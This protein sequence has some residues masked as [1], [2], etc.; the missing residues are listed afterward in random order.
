MFRA[1]EETIANAAAIRDYL[2][3]GPGSIAVDE[4]DLYDRESRRAFLLLWNADTRAARKV[5]GWSVAG[6]NSSTCSRP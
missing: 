2:N 6:E 3:E 5:S 4:T 1:N